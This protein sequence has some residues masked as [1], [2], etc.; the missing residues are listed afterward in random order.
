MEPPR[1]TTS[2]NS[3]SHRPS[4]QSLRN[5]STADGPE[6]SAFNH[7]R[8][9]NLTRRGHS[10]GDLLINASIPPRTHR[11]ASTSEDSSWMEHV[12]QPPE[13]QD[14]GRASLD[15][16]A[17][18][19]AMMFEDRRRRLSD[20]MDDH[21]KRPSMG[22]PFNHHMHPRPRHITTASFSDRTP[23]GP[24]IHPR[25]RFP[26]RVID[27]PLLRRPSEEI[28]HDRR[29]RELRLPKWQ[30]DE[31]VSRCPICGITFTFW[32]RKHHC[33]KCGR[34]VCANCSPH[35]ITIPR[36]F[37]IHPLEATAQSPGERSSV[38]GEVVDL[39]D[40]DV[41]GPR[42]IERP[43]SSDYKIDPALGGGQEVRLCNP[44]V[45]DPNP[46]PHVPYQPR[47]PPR[48]ESRPRPDRRSFGE[49]RGFNS[50]WP[51]FDTTPPSLA[52]RI[53]SNQQ[54]PRRRSANA[55]EFDAHLNSFPSSSSHRHSHAPH[56]PLHSMGPPP[57]PAV[58]GSAPD[59]AI[60]QVS[61]L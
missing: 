40:D 55:T 6:P 43:Q 20:Q 61:R 35:R 44:C 29:N 15:M 49:G 17:R 46:L 22:M 16:A 4:D 19:R 18:R 36:Q 42:I 27:R 52:S 2:L 10:D 32:Y 28:L 8:A 7:E 13:R 9:S 33:R 3:I 31:E 38:A 41:D 1:R 39:T 30:P 57:L 45:P 60:H 59:Q 12:R 11:N 21:D 26:P 48:F 23:F 37:I 24:S 47:D 56:T 14:H 50:Q 58:Y 34:V 53:S 5:P 51:S 25:N 54:D